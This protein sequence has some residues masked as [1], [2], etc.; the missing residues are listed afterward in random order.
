MKALHEG[1]RYF[2]IAAIIDEDKTLGDLADEDRPGLSKAHLVLDT[3]QVFEG[4]K[5]ELWTTVACLIR[6]T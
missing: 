6:L 1:R 5:R 4:E 3:Y 2:F